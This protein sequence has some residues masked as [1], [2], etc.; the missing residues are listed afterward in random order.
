IRIRQI[1]MN[2][3]LNASDALGDNA[4]NIC[5]RVSRVN[6]EPASEMEDE[7][8]FPP[9]ECLRL[10]VSDTGC[11]MSDEQRTRMFDPF[12]TTKHTGNGLGLAVVR[13]IVESHGGMIHVAS[14]LGRGTTVEVFLPFLRESAA[15][16]SWVAQAA[17]SPS[18]CSYDSG[19]SE[20]LVETRGATPLLYR[21]GSESRHVEA[22]APH[23]FAD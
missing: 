4:G 20:Q 23:G 10:E 3:L 21:R 14:V 19:L 22:C 5:I 12:F 17:A 15:K 7:V 9:G 6:R 1:V 2:L 16:D 13:G 8:V 11:G 18:I